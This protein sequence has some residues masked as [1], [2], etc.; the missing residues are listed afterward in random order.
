MQ[1]K[2]SPS[3]FEWISF[4]NNKAPLLC[5]LLS[6][7]TKFHTLE[8]KA[9]IQLLFFFFPF[10][11]TSLKIIQ[12]K[13]LGYLNSKVCKKKCLLCYM[14]L[15]LSSFNTRLRFNLYFQIIKWLDTK[16]WNC[17][18]NQAALYKIKYDLHQKGKRKQGG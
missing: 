10:N 9:C 12:Y 5:L 13:I 3:L 11:F 6:F 16:K 8:D 7:S 4:G 18:A 14:L 15:I 1:T 2:S 17:Q